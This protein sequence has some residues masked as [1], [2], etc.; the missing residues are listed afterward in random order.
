MCTGISIKYTKYMVP[1]YAIFPLT[2][3]NIRGTGGRII[4]TF[5]LKIMLDG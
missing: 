4:V 3:M 5:S 2:L 1:A